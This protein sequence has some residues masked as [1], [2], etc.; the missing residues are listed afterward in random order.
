M[1]YRQLEDFIGRIFAYKPGLL[2]TD[3]ATLHKRV[4]KQDLG[5]DVSENGAIVAVDSTGI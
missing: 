5:I 2:A 3:Y 4:S 1:P